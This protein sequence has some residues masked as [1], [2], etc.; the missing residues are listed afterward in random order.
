MK[1]KSIIL[2]L[3]LSSLSSV[4]MIKHAASKSVIYVYN[5][6]GVSAESLKQLLHTLKSSTANQ[7]KIRTI[8]AKQVI[9]GHWTQ[10][11]VLFV[12]PGGADIPYTKKLAGKGNRVIKRF[13]QNGGRYL[14]V[15]AGSYYASS[16]VEF[17][18]GGAFEVLGKRELAFF[19][20]KAIGPILATYDYKTNSGARA[21]SIEMHLDSVHDVTLYYNGGN[22]FEHAENYPNI[23]VLGRYTG[24]AGRHLPA[25]IHIHYGQGN[26]VLSGVHF[27]YDPFLLDETDKHLN[28]IIPVLKKENESRKRL[29]NNLIHSTL[30]L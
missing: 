22:F 30:S 17:D 11:A 25:I 15:C 16:Y 4:F 23:T 5:D 3:L 9:N 19:P 12:L 28:K 2:I 20:G 8:N 14:G 26:V 29:V 10:H 21:A 27:E 7:Y 18:K 13:V 24:V 6:E 1:R